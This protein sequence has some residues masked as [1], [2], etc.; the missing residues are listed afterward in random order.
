M[1]PG[2]FGVQSLIVLTL[3]LLVSWP[4]QRDL[5]AITLWQTGPDGAG[6][7]NDASASS[8]MGRRGSYE[9]GYGSA[10]YQGSADA[11]TRR[12]YENDIEG[13]RRGRISPQVLAL[14]GT[15]NALIGRTRTALSAPVPFARLLLRNIATGQVE[16]RATADEHGRFTFVDVA[17]SAYVVELIGPDGS[18]VATSEL[19]AI[20]AGDV[21]ETT[22]R[23]SLPI[24][25]AGA[26]VGG[27]AS[28]VVAAAEEGGVRRVAQ[29]ERAIS[30]RR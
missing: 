19:V 21:R 1:T 4:Q 13:R 8:R 7:S 9:I 30:P 17:P 2:R 6:T 11:V 18:V 25:A 24:V 3:I 10:S 5:P 15:L 23:L 20:D 14:G 22:V 29:P 26:G 16:A 28:E 27:S 12:L